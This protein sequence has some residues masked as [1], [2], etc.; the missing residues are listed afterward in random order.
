MTRDTGLLTAD[1]IDFMSLMVLV[2]GI[3]EPSVP[4]V[5]SLRAKER[6]GI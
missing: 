5:L 2:A 3:M 6:H 4:Q 1:V